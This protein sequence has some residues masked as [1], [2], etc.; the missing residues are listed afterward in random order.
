MI[1]RMFSEKKICVL[2]HES[3][4]VGP[5]GLNPIM[6]VALLDLIGY[7]P[8]SKTSQ[9]SNDVCPGQLGRVAI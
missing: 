4:Q 8:T 1:E 3:R 5:A 6:H 2:L 9:A 7:H